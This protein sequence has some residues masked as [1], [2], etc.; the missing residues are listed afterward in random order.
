MQKLQ[1]PIDLI[2]ESFQIYFKRENLV[3]LLKFALAGFLVGILAALPFIILAILGVG[4]GALASFSDYGAPFLT[5]VVLLFVVGIIFSITIGVW[6]QAA[7]IMAISQV[8]KG[9]QLSVESAFRS[10]WGKIVWRLFF[11]NMLS[12]LVVVLGLVLLIIPGIIFAVWFSFVSFVLVTENLG[13]MES[14][15]RSKSL[16]SGYFWAVVGRFLVFFL[17]I[18][19]LEIAISLIPFIGSIVL[20]LFSPFGVLLPYLVFEDLKKVKAPSEIANASH[21]AP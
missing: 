11:A 16:V 18:A 6:L 3:F 1:S 13:A 9:G 5:I 2:K 7:Q 12:G 20:M 15:K 10:S 17:L 4:A 19:V 14:L 8:I 21:G